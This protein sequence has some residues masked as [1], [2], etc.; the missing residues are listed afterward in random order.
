MEISYRNE[1]GKLLE[2]LGLKGDA[3]ELGNAEGRHAQVLISQS[4][5][6]KLYLIDS[7]QTLNQSGDGAREQE[8]HDNN[9]KECHERVEPWKEKAV[10]L[11]GLSSEMIKHIPDDSLVLAYIDGDHSYKGCMADLVAIYPKVKKGGILS[12]H[13]VLSLS[14]GVNLAVKDF[15]DENGYTQQDIHYTEEDGDRAMVSCW[16]IKK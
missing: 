16:F 12:L 5:I 11:K 8:W 14:Y 10:F 7:W 9:F 13:D 4:A 1:L 2:Y 6:T 3:V 15:R